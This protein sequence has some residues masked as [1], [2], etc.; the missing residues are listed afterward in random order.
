MRFKRGKSIKANQVNI[1]G[2]DN[3]STG[4]AKWGNELKINLIR[5]E[6][7]ERSRGRGFMER[8]EEGF[9]EGME[10]DL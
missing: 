4:N 10:F 3:T 9:M 2:S 5:I 8:M 6:E 7:R 1:N